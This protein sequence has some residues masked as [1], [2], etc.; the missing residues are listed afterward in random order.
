MKK[1]LLI[2]LCVLLSVSWAFA[3]GDE[4]T[5]PKGLLLDNPAGP[6]I[7]AYQTEQTLFKASTQEMAAWKKASWQQV[8]NAI[9]TG[10]Y[11]ANASGSIQSPP[12]ILPSLAN[13]SARIN[14]YLRESYELESYHDKGL[15]QVS[16]DNGVTW[17]T[18][19]TRTGRS[20][21]RTSVINVSEYAGKTIRVA[22][23]IAAD[24]SNNYNG[25]SVE[26]LS[27]VQDR[28]KP[29]S[30]RSLITNA[31]S[32]ART[33]GN[34]VAVTPMGSGGTVSPLGV[35]S[36]QI[37]SVDANLFPRYIF[38]QLH[39]NDGTTPLL[40]LTAADF[41]V[42]EYVYNVTTGTTDTL[43]ARR[44]ETYLVY[45]PDLDTVRKPVDIV[46]LMDNSGSMSDEQ[47]AV[48]ANVA[49]FVNALDGQG[50]DYRLGLC[51]FGQGASNGI[52][53]FHNN[54][55][56][57]TNAAQ[58]I[59]VWNSVNTIDGGI[60][61]SWDALYQ[62]STQ[63]SF[64]TGA[65]KIFIL[66]TD[67][68]ITNNNISWSQITDRQIVINQLINAGV[69]TY[70]LVTP[71]TPFDYDFG[72]IATATGG[73][74]Y[75]ITSPFN[76]ILQD[77]GEEINGTYTIRYA[78]T[79][80]YFDGRQRQVEVTANY[81]GQSIKMFGTYTPGA[82]PIIIRTDPTLA[83]HRTAQL[84]NTAITIEIEAID[85]DAITTNAVNLFYRKAGTTGTY[86]QLTMTR[87]TLTPGN[88]ATNTPTR[89]KWQATI[90]AAQ[91][92]D[93]GIEYYIRA[94]DGQ[95][96]TTAPEFIDRPG[97]PFSFAVLP[98]LPPVL[99]H[100]PLQTAD[101]KSP[102]VITAEAIDNTNFV[103]QVILAWKR[104][105]DLL[106]TEVPMTLVAGTNNYT[107]T[108]PALNTNT[109]VSYYIRAVDNFNVSTFSASAT[110]PNTI[111]VGVPWPQPT[112]PIIHTIRFFKTG[113]N[114]ATV[115][116][117]GQ[118][119]QNGDI[120]GV[121]YKDAGG[122][123]KPAGNVTWSSAAIITF[124]VYGDNPAT[125]E[126][127]GFAQ[128]E[129]F[130]FKVYRLAD[131]EIY[132]AEYS[133]LSSAISVTNFQSG[134][135]SFVTQLN[136]Y[137]VQDIALNPGLN[138]VSTYLTPRGT[139][140]FAT[141]TAPISTSVSSIEDSYGAS[142]P[143]N[144][145]TALV[146]HTTGYGYRFYMN[147]AATWH[148]EGAKLAPANVRLSL[149]VDGTIAG[150]PYPKPENVE[151]VFPVN[152]QHIYIVDR[153]IT[154]A[155]GNL[156]IE[157][158]SPM[159]DLNTWTNKNMEPG[160]GYYVYSDI[161]QQFAYPSPTGAHARVASS[162]REAKTQVAQ[163]ITSI[164]DYM[165]V[166]LPKEAWSKVSL[167]D[168]VRVYNRKGVMIGRA[169]VTNNGGIVTLD[170]ALIKAD[171][172][173]YL[174]AWYEKSATEES[175]SITE[176]KAGSP[177]YASH[178]IA[179]VGAIGRQTEVTGESSVAIFPNPIQN[180]INV[181]FVL[182][183]ESEVSIDVIDAKGNRVLNPVN[184]QVYAEG[185]HKVSFGRQS[186]VSGLYLIKVST[187]VAFEMKRIVVK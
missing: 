139:S 5:Q 72:G 69:K 158:Y 54:A 51:R 78:P 59:S 159:F 28:L 42:R 61:P 133:I 77:I 65:Q 4:R 43:P 3:Q 62:S 20:D 64:R 147:N 84:N 12:I 1:R 48:S 16:A 168:E 110:Y 105:E 120:I 101:P 74:N 81:N 52:P 83:I 109:I 160:R 6:A 145:G 58:F 108:I 97:Y 142:Y 130:T 123:L 100:T 137:S 141:L 85:Y 71:G 11:S 102:I 35:L 148:V 67:E 47:A 49:S 129:L 150:S 99:N 21:W 2:F 82:A 181:S 76:D 79:Y 95:S 73:R 94:T 23:R 44:D 172:R 56:F 80:P 57:Y 25:W 45:T 155:G 36:G 63:Y 183:E 40:T 157:S 50:Y 98:N 162:G 89:S 132:D 96:T 60:E 121:F 185:E 10:R 151:S 24:Q 55:F 135:Q 15:V 144:G 138:L 125:T 178:K 165:H 33:A 41:F 140:S 9:S 18:V 8:G 166:I 90:P 146:N 17:K 104:E 175:L 70:T 128:N 180:D 87:T 93:P 46:F 26:Q 164:N 152:D 31:P 27:V 182:E 118:P 38:T 117:D 153:Y 186:L 154:D 68:S 122:A 111:A 19:S 115:T 112:S 171:E 136:A 7:D 14:L 127:D 161:A 134:K 156:T 30:S 176:W 34:D 91:V 126:K 169:T 119:I 184:K 167:A 86:N 106:Y 13:A 103:S 124:P 179:V 116:I 66:I 131:G 88:P 107:Y 75:N 37:T 143:A 32:T 39:V 113:A 149:S 92:L 114:A 173:F 177:L 29:V 174:R 22:F 187:G 170:G 53:L 163:L